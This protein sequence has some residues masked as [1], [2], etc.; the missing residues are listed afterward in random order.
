MPSLGVS[1]LTWDRACANVGRGPFSLER[2]KMASFKNLRRVIGA[3]SADIH[4]RT[5]KTRP[6]RLIPSPTVHASFIHPGTVFV[7]PVPRN[8]DIET[9]GHDQPDAERTDAPAD[10]SGSGVDGR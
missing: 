6:K 7:R 8:V 9:S 5:R 1:S 3:K 4:V 2:C 10:P